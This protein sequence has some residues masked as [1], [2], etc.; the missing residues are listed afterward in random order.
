M[1]VCIYL[2]ELLLVDLQCCEDWFQWSFSPALLISTPVYC[3]LTMTLGKTPCV[4]H[5]CW[6][7]KQRPGMASIAQPQTDPQASRWLRGSRMKCSPPHVPPTPKP[8]NGA[9]VSPLAGPE[10]R[11]CWPLPRSPGLWPGGSAC[12]PL[13][14]VLPGVPEA[15]QAPSPTPPTPAEAPL[16]PVSLG[17]SPRVSWGPPRCWAPP[18]A[19]APR[20][21]DGGRGGAPACVC[22]RAPACGAPVSGDGPSGASALGER[23]LWVRRGSWISPR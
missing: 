20:R 16:C 22:P 7:S 6:A 5:N 21:E 2:F 15:D 10:P 8:L 14:L 12:D 13:P 3:H 4:P 11:A 17:T 23:L 19:L 1:S 18:V 9:G